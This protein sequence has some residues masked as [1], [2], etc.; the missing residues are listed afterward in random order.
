MISLTIKLM[1]GYLFDIQFDTDSTPDNLYRIVWNTLPSY[2]KTNKTK[3]YNM[4]LI[5]TGEK[6]NEGWIRPVGN[7]TRIPQKYMSPLEDKE[8]IFVFF[9]TINYKFKADEINDN[10]FLITIYKDIEEDSIYSEIIYIDDYGMSFYFEDE[11]NLNNNEFEF[12]G[13]G[14][15]DFMD[16]LNKIEISPCAKELLYSELFETFSFIL[17]EDVELF[18]DCP[19]YDLIN[20][21]YNNL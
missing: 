7:P 10:C 2:I 12:F 15:I 20:K 17:P 18:Q 21:E 13:G 3:I 4:M 8:V 1:N 19:I 5:R 11:V 16:L 9:E 6:E 14:H